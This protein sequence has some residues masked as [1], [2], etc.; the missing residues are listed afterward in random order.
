MLR[1]FTIGASEMSMKFTIVSN[2]LCI[3]LKAKKVV[4]W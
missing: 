1:L 4:E 2:E 3:Q